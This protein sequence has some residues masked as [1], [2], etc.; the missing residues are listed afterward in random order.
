MGAQY[1]EFRA[2]CS[3]SWFSGTTQDHEVREQ[4]VRDH[5]AERGA[6]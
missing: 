5:L 4:R 1:S 3:C 6:T 2:F